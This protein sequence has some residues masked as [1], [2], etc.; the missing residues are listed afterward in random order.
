MPVHELALIHELSE[1]VTI[2][3][4]FK[5]MNK[6]KAREQNKFSWLFMKVSFFVVQEQFMNTLMNVYERS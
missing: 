3:E 4:Q 6:V 2:H 5:L 1:F